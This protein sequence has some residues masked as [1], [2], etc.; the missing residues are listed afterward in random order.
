MLIFSTHSR[1]G[2]VA[3]TLSLYS[4][5]SSLDPVTGSRHPV[6]AQRHHFKFGVIVLWR[7]PGDHICY[8]TL[9]TA[10]LSPTCR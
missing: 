3:S 6:P 10:L 2:A 9:Q 8:L 1:L 7:P 5:L 4:A